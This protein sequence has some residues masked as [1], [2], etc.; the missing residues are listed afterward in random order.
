M[1]SLCTGDVSHLLRCDDDLYYASSGFAVNAVATQKVSFVASMRPEHSTYWLDV[2]KTNTQDNDLR[3][4]L[5]RQRESGNII[6]AYSAT[7]VS[8]I[9]WYATGHMQPVLEAVQSIHFIGKKRTS[10][11]GEVSQWEAEASDLDGLVGYGAEPLRPVPTE[12]WTGSSNLIPVEAAWKAP[13]WE[14]KNR[15]R[16]F[17]P[18]I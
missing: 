11:Y 7:V 3:I 6:N 17:V 1:S 10:G 18:E 13:Y 14:V 4:G 12:R 16:C 2:I 5:T 15:T 9:E 8:A